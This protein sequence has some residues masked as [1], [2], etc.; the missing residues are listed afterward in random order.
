MSGPE[1]LNQ[2]EVPPSNIAELLGKLLEAGEGL[3][4]Q[5]LLSVLEERLSQHT[6]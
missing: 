1:L 4:E 2:I 3:K 6:R 5:M